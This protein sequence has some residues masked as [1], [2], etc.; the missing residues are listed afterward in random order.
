MKEGYAIF[1]F[2]EGG[3]GLKRLEKQRVKEMSILKTKQNKNPETT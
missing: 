2:T 1:M 3:L